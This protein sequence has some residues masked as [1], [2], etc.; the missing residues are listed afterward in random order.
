MPPSDGAP[1]QSVWS[2]NP[3]LW[4]TLGL[5]VACHGLRQG[6][7]VGWPG[8][9]AA[10]LAKIPV[11]RLAAKPRVQLPKSQTSN[12]LHRSLQ[13]TGVAVQIGSSCRNASVPAKRAESPATLLEQLRRI[14]QQTVQTADGR[15]LTG[16]TEMTPAQKS[17]FAVL[18]LGTAHPRKPLQTR[19]VVC[20]WTPVS[21]QINHLR[22]GSE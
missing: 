11:F 16:L 17:L 22:A 6:A 7:C 13:L 15:T 18:E 5:C 14:D 8:L 20:D 2:K 19:F 9:A 10:L 21:N 3:K 12:Q 4:P 1:K